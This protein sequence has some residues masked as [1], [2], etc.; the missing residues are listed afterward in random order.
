MKKEL[1]A[2]KIAVKYS[3]VFKR[4]ANA[5]DSEHDILLDGK[6]V[7]SVSR[8]WSRNGGKG[9]IVEMPNQA[10]SLAKANLAD[11]REYVAD[12]MRSQ[13]ARIMDESAR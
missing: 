5:H 12:K 6:R 11:C 2:Y 1:H 8:G 9:W 13:L 3:L 4:I 7:A 10:V